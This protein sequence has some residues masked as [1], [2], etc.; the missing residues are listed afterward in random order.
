MSAADQEKLVQRLAFRY[1]EKRE[2]G[3]LRS[4]N[5]SRDRTSELLANFGPFV[6]GVGGCE[7]KSIGW[8][9]HHSD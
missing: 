5:I 2:E 9:G 3:D 6:E 4:F 7:S 8:H 1:C